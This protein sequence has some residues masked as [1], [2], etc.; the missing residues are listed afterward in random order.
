MRAAMIRQAISLFVIVGLPIVSDCFAQITFTPAELRRMVE[1]GKPPKQGAPS[2]RSEPMNYASC[3][4][5]I[6]AIVA[7][8]RPNYPTETILSTNIGLI[9]KVWTNDAAMTFTCS[10]P[11][12][13]LVITTSKY[14]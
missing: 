13:R 7:S 4:A 3:V 14:L 5:K 8:V 9:E 6:K 1:A 12:N 2:T 11:D 10:A